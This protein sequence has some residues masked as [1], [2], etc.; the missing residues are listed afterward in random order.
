MEGSAGKGRLREHPTPPD[1]TAA[2][3]T[4]ET[5]APTEVECCSDEVVIWAGTKREKAVAAGGEGSDTKFCF[6]GFVGQRLHLFLLYIDDQQLHTDYIHVL[7]TDTRPSNTLHYFF[8][9]P[10]LSCPDIF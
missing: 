8:N 1:G 2:V 3:T 4:G 5:M 7:Y 9:Y 6:L 10:M